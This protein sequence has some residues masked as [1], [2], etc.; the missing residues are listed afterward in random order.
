MF[1][2]L[3]WGIHPDCH[4]TKTAGKLIETGKLP[5]SVIL[6]IRQHIG[7][8]AVLKVRRGDKVKKGQLLAAGEAAVSSNIH[9]SISGEIT[10]I[11]IA[12]HPVYGDCQAIF[13]AGDGLDEWA[14]G[15]LTERNWES[16]GREETIE[17]IRQAGII[18]MGGAAFPTHVKLM[19]PKDKPIDTLIVN[20][21]ECE[22]YLTVDHRIMVEE[23]E[24]VVTGIRI[25]MKLLQPKQA[26]V[27]IEDNK[28]DAI[29]AMTAALT[30][31]GV[32]VV[33][34]PTKYPQGAEKMLIRT[35]VNRLVAPGRLPMDVGVL[36]QNIS[37]S[38]ALCDA[39]TRGI[40]LIERVVTITGGAVKEPKN[41]RLRLG[42]TFAD[43]IEQCGG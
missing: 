12:P 19:P 38:V 8:P 21:A 13:I 40:P 23:T 6:P 43:A 33:P 41:L 2:L 36:V 35:L 1:S 37:T 15:I 39:V 34:V 32:K 27:G 42:T 3:E 16:L 18:G 30:P 10:E 31:Y 24:K 5:S 17:I 4:K 7:A 20:A 11:R 28:P 14:D 22:P 26:I 9:A 29:A 25:V